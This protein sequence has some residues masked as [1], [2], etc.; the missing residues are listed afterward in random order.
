ME[1]AR[2]LAELGVELISTGGTFRALT[3]AGVPVRE[4]ASVTGFPEM[5]DGRVKTIHPKIAGGILAIRGNQEH[6]HAIDEHGIPKI[7]MVV[8]NLYAFEKIAARPDAAVPELIENIDIGGPTMIRAAAKN[9][10]D[11]AV[12]TSPDDYTPVLNEMKSN[13]GSRAVHALA[14]RGE[15]VRSHRPL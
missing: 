7:D 6:M 14:T 10:Q 8:V 15:S 1:F 5:L 11:V 4:V 3:D 13:G 12:V 9:Y 2:G